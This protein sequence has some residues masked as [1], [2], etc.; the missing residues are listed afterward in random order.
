L[1]QKQAEEV[2]FLFAKSQKILGFSFLFGDDFNFM[3]VTNNLITLYDVKFSKQKA[4]TVKQLPITSVTDNITMFI[5]PLANLIVLVD[6]KGQCQTYFLNQYKNK[7]H[8]G[9]L[10]NLDSSL[11]NPETEQQ[12]ASQANASTTGSALQ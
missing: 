5:E 12:L 11:P 10:F 7:N 9:K 1:K 4:K 8:K 2:R 6:S 3:V